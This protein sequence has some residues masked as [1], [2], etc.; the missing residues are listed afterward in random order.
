M[1][2]I[3]VKEDMTKCRLNLLTHTQRTY[4][5]VELRGWLRKPPIKSLDC[6]P[7]CSFLIHLI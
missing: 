2:L 1:K 5:Y 4:V 6:F 3:S 7:E